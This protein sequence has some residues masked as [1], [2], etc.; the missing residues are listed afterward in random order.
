MVSKS[1]NYDLGTA[2]GKIDIDASGAR[3][4]SK[5]A[6]DSVDQ[7]TRGLKDNEKQSRKTEGAGKD[8]SGGLIAAGIGTRIL[9]NALKGLAIVGLV[10]GISFAIGAVGGLFVW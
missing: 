1:A 8:L 10:Q 2:R 7:Y 4:G 9:S 3:R 5:Q 6:K